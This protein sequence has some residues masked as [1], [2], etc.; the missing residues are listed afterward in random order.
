M[1]CSETAIRYSE[2]LGGSQQLGW[3]LNTLEE[4]RVAQ[5]EWTVMDVRDLIRRDRFRMLQRGTPSVAASHC[6]PCGYGRLRR[7]GPPS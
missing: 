7:V 3:A 6:S 5:C 1:A 4:G 2:S